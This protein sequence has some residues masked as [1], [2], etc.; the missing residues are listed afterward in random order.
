MA[1]WIAVKVENEIHDSLADQARKKDL[2]LAQYVRQ[3]FKRQAKTMSTRRR[4]TTARQDYVCDQFRC[5]HGV[6]PK[7]SEY[8]TVSTPPNSDIGNTTWWT[9]RHDSECDA[10]YVESPFHPGQSKAEKK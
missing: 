2:S 10:Y 7:G 8:V 6:I 9:L 4:V 5:R 1:K 3:L